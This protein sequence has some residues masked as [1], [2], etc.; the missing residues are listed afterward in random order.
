MGDASS[1]VHLH[2]Q[3]LTYTHAAAATKFTLPAEIVKALPSGST[4]NATAALEACQADFA[5]EAG[6]CSS[7][8]QMALSRVRTHR[9]L[10]LFHLLLRPLN[11][12]TCASDTQRCHVLHIA[13]TQ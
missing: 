3:V 5:T 12:T 11:C 9:L 7:A 1:M 4:C 13:Q 8:C 6:C 10:L 2:A